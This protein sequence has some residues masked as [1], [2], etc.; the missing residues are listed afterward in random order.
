ML[1]PKELRALSDVMPR[2]LAVLGAASPLLHIDSGTFTTV[3]NT[4]VHTQYTWTTRE[5]LS[6]TLTDHFESLDVNQDGVLQLDEFERWV[7]IRKLYPPPGS[8]PGALAQR[9]AAW[10]KLL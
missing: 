1:E 7:K 6:G 10:I 2:E 5:A 3:K 8:P 4:T 9:L